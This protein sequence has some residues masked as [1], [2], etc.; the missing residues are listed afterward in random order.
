MSVAA[1][2]IGSAALAYFALF[3][4]GPLLAAES[5]TRMQVSPEGG[6]HCIEVA[7]R[8]I[9]PG[10]RMQM[11]DCSNAPAQMFTYDSKNM[12]LTIGGLCVDAF[13]G[14]P[15][16][17]LQLATCHAGPSQI[18]KLEPKGSFDKLVGLNGLCLDVRFGSTERGAFV[19]V[20]TCAD[21]APNQRWSFQ[22]Q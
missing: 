12:R 6:G 21:D 17:I 11:E 1:L 4:G 16:D 5:T 22:H 20:W 10:Q 2:R 19:Q 9:A 13:P 7:D 18:W 8:R 14:Q 3:A 15:G